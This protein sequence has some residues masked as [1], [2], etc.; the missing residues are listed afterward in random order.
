MPEWITK[1]MQDF[2]T[3]FIV[4]DR[5]KY[6]VEGIQ[7]TLILTV[8]ALLLGVALAFVIAVFV[9]SFGD[10]LKINKKK[11]LIESIKARNST[12]EA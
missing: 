3:A 7:N 12:E 4:D 9:S 2:N 1:L 11:K 8:F 5:W 6:L 10:R